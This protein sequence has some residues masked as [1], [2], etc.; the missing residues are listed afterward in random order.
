MT[1]LQDGGIVLGSFLSVLGRAVFTMVLA[2]PVL[3]LFW[4]AAGG[5]PA[6]SLRRL[7][8]VFGIGVFGSPML[9]L[10]AE[11]AIIGLA[12]VV[13][14]IFSLAH[15]EWLTLLKQLKNQIANSAD[16]QTTV[17]LLAPYLSNPLILLGVLAFAAGIGPLIEEAAKP[18][19]VWLVGKRLQSPAEGFALG[20]LCGAGFALLEGL[21]AASGASQSWGIGIGVRALSSLMHI[22]ASGIMGWGIASALLEK[23]YL[24]LAGA[25]LTSFL[26]HGLWNGSVVLVVY[27][28]AQ[29]AILNGQKIDVAST[30]II[31]VGLAMLL[32][33]LCMILVFLPLFNRMLRPAS[34]PAPQG[35]PEP[36]EIVV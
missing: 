34:P 35:P 16:I 2:L 25:Y 31:L 4:I 11:Y 8:S 27:G 21:S 22:S 30:V 1:G 33:L 9:A 3:A 13:V 29:M 32:L 19:A 17:T 6:G 26:I 20:A 23:R 14:G 28:A 5:L 7:A 15:P 24:R 12:L 18:L 10:V 36:P